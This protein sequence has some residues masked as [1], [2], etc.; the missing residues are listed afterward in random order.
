MEVIWSDIATKHLESI[1]DYVEQEFGVNTA[2]KT[3]SKISTE[4]H[5]LFMLSGCYSYCSYCSHKAIS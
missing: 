1:L 2:A 4:Y 3:L 5:I